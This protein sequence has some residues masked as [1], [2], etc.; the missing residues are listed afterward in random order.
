MPVIGRVGLWCCVL[1][2]AWTVLVGSS[3]PGADQLATLL[4]AGPCLGS[5]DAT[6]DTAGGLPDRGGSILTSTGMPRQALIKPQA[7]LVLA[8]F[9][10]R[11]GDGGELVLAPEVGADPDLLT[12]SVH[13]PV[14]VP[15][16]GRACGALSRVPRGPPALWRG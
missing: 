1:L 16:R 14:A 10:D 8:G 2:A 12:W 5:T 6:A 9:S 15:D 11:R 3:G 7:P 4:R 13:V